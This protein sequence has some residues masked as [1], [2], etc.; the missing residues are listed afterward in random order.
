[1]DALA[2]YSL[3]L[4]AVAAMLIFYPL[5][6]PEGAGEAVVAVNR[7]WFARERMEP[8]ADVTFYLDRIT[9]TYASHRGRSCGRNIS[10][11]PPYGA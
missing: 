6:Q 11:L 2:Y 10:P 1:M 9:S 8:E 4:F 5:D 3:D 7:E